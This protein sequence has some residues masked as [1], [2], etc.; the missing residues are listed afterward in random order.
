[1]R[2]RIKHFCA[3]YFTVRYSIHWWMPEKTFGYAETRSAFPSLMRRNDMKLFLLEEAHKLA[4]SLT[5]E[6]IRQ[7]EAEQADIY[8]KG[9]ARAVEVRRA[10][11]MA[12]QEIL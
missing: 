8:E 9:V 4:K 5:P 3:E 1:M 6:K 2:V 11:K 7:H 10:G 12:E